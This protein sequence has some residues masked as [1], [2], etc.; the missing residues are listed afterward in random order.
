MR[1]L[2][3]LRLGHS[4]QRRERTAQLRLAQAKQKIRLILAR[5]DALA[6]NSAP[7]VPKCRDYGML[8][9]RVMSG[10]DIIAAKRFR[11]TP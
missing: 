7:V 4:A 5:I 6:Q 11:L 9:N 2:P 3:D 10:G 1:D 8:D